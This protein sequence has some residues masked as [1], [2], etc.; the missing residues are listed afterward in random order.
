METTKVRVRR[1]VAEKRRIVELTFQPGQSVA[2]VAQ[3]EGVNSHQVFQWRRAYRAGELVVA[4]EHASSLLPVIVSATGSSSLVER[5]QTVSQERQFRRAR[6]TSSCGAASRSPWSVVRT[7]QCC[8]RFWRPC[9]SDRAA[10]RHTHLYRR[11]RDRYAARLSGA[12]CTGAD[13]TQAATIFRTRLCF[14]GA[15]ATRSR[16]YGPMKT[17]CVCLRSDWNADASSGRKRRKERFL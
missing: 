8:K 10:N 6:F 2:R 12:E 1:S 9:G 4:G 16:F 3:A 15:G 7:E 14:R 11:R 5:Q 17:V 13:D